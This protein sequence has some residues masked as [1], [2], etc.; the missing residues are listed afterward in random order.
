[1]AMP[2]SADTTAMCSF[3]LDWKT[4]SGVRNSSSARCH[5]VC[6]STGHRCTSKPCKPCKRHSGRE[7]KW[8]LFVTRT[9]FRLPCLQMWW[10]SP[11]EFHFPN[12]PCMEYVPTF[13]YIY[14]WNNLNTI[15]GASGYSGWWF[16][17]INMVQHGSTT[18]Q[19]PWMMPFGGAMHV[20][21]SP[22]SEE[23]FAGLQ[24]VHFL[25]TSGDQQPM[26]PS[27]RPPWWLLIYW[28]WL[29]VVLTMG[30]ILT[31]CLVITCYNQCML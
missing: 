29:E 14:H 30:L 24:L 2:T 20:A 1:M 9:C 26:G 21:P 6:G 11:S 23:A 4:G 16:N 31:L 8:C 3:C 12:V 15:H 19:V 10:W 22:S 5:W 17:M 25:A 28:L 18:T 7:L 27:K 13:T